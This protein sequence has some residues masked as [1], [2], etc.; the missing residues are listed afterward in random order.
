M[1]TPEGFEEVARLYRHDGG[2][3]DYVRRGGGYVSATGARGKLSRTR[4]G[5]TYRSNDG[6]VETYDEHG[7][8]TRLRSQ[9]SEDIT[10]LYSDGSTPPTVAPAQGLLIRATDQQGRA[11][12]IVYD[13]VG[14]V[15]SVTDGQ[16]NGA[17]YAYVE[18]DGK[19][20]EADLSRVLYA[21][22]SSMEYRYNERE[23][24]QGLSQPHLL[25]GIIDENG[26]RFATFGYDAQGHA[27]STTHALG[28]E[29]TFILNETDDRKTVRGP[30]GALHAYE[31]SKIRGSRRLVSV[32]QPGGAGCG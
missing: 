19:K 6:D 26:V 10:F 9:G 27:V 22:G 13:L 20:L 18:T 17:T 16:G 30:T 2:R 28:A 1:T 12:S 31:F 21:D 15:T 11:L 29:A 32:N 24:T 7:I 25:T 23:H 14:R 5:W 4:D 8:L 3:I